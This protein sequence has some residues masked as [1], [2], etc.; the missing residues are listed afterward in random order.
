MDKFTVY[1][2][3]TV[4][5][6]N[7]N[8]DTDQIL[9]KQFL[10]LIDK[11]GFGKY[12]MYEW[13]YL[14]DKYTEDPDFIFN[15]PAYRKATILVTGDNFGAGSSREHAAWALADY[16]FKVI[17][18]GSFGDIHYNNDLNNGVL[19]IVQPLEVRQK[20]ASLDPDDEVTV[21]LHEQK[22]ISPVGEF[23]FDIDGEWKNKL[24]KGLDD[25]GITLQYEELIAD[26]EKR[27][28][29]YWQ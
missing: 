7:D 18:A 24:L 12:L 6:M 2:G 20:L 13:R 9:P 23:H 25:I 15:Q 16:G 3:T 17:I 8:I 19:P 27:R 4:P 28:P 10:K 5:L 22:I 29:R 11:K 26:Y 1:T 14:D 21:N